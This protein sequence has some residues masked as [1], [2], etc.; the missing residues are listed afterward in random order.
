MKGS[1]GN[2]LNPIFW[3]K[4]RGKNII[5]GERLQNTKYLESKCCL[6]QMPKVTSIL[7]LD[8]LSESKSQLVN[9]RKQKVALNPGTAPPHPPPHQF[10]TP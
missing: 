3:K 2:M 5:G 7:V 10:Q 9:Q 1:D 4:V 8:H 6:R